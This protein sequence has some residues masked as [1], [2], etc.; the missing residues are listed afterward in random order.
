MTRTEI[1][2]RIK[3]L[4][5]CTFLES[6]LELISLKTSSDYTYNKAI[7]LVEKQ[8]PQKDWYSVNYKN[9]FKTWNDADIFLDGFFLAKNTDFR[10]RDNE[11]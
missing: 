1:E 10:Y 4:N 2:Q 3:C 9:C 7:A 11:R 5:E 6:P 8:S